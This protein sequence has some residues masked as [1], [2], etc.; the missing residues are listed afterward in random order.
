MKINIVQGDKSYSAD[1]G[2]GHDIS[3]RLVSGEGPNCF[4]APLFESAPVKAGDF[5]GS[6]QAGGIVNFYNV[7]MNPH[8]NGTHTECV[9]HISTEK[10]V[11][12]DVLTNSHSVAKLIS[13]YPYRKENGDLAITPEVICDHLQD[14]NSE[15]LIVRTLPNDDTKRRRMY[16]DTNPP[17]FDHRAI[18]MVREAG[19]KHLVTDLPSVDREVDEGK[20]LGHKAFWQYPETVDHEKTITELVYVDNLIKDGLYLCNIQI[21]NIDLDASPSRIIL[22]DLESDD[23]I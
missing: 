12:P 15:T 4:Y 10:V 13:V 21:I 22:Y 2:K 5:V 3:I 6:T 11:V 14:F 20:L 7:R 19:V 16:S 1:L 17:Y 23:K 18:Q 9:G 8:G